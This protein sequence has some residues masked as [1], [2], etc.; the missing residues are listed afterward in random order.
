M[1][2]GSNDSGRGNGDEV[3]GTVKWFNVSK[4]FGFV[5]PLGGGGDIFVHLSALRQRG[6]DSI[7]EGATIACRVVQ[8]PKG[9]QAV[10][11]IEVDHSTSVPSKPVSGPPPI[12]AKG[13]SFVATVKWF[14]PEKGYGFITRGEESQDVFVHI[15]T[16]RRVGI[17]QLLPGQ[18]VR[19][20]VGQGPK[21]PQVAEIELVED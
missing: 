3:R 19:V 9:M 21:G 13:D 5:T 15:K 2:E 12:E 1:V 6:F 17:E 18:S 11:I 14:N 10:E 16:L 20:R 8:G 4:G 7:E